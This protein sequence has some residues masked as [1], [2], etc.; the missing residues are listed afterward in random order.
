MKWKPPVQDV[1]CDY[2]APKKKSGAEK[3]QEE[4]GSISRCPWG[5]AISSRES[6]VLTPVEI[7]FIEFC[8]ELGYGE[9]ERIVVRNGEPLEVEVA[10]R[11]IRFDKEEGGA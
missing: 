8:R 6:I 7:R 3:K 11:K 1:F 9:L 4:I 2:T 5:E 10:R